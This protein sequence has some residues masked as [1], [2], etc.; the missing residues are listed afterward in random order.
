MTALTYRYVALTDTGLRRSTNQDSGYASDRLLAIADGMGG[1]AAGDLASS[2]AMHII[3]RLDRDLDVSAID[4]LDQ[5]VKLAND[6]LGEL[7]REDP[8]V[9][10]MGT[11]LEVMVWDGEKLAVAHLGDS[12]AY[13]LRGGTLTQISTD[14]TFVQS[15]VE[16]GKISRAEARVHPH[17]SLLLRALLGR[18]DN[19][20]DLSWIQPMLGDRYLLCSDGLT[21][22]VEDDVIQR[23]LSAE[24]ID[25]A[26]TELVRLALEAGGVDNVTVV[27]AEF[28]EK[29]TEPDPHLSSSDGQPQLV[30]AAANQARPRTGTASSGSDSAVELDPEEL[31]YAPQPPARRRW[32]R[33]TAAIVVVAAI[34]AAGGAYAYNWS[35]DQFYVAAS[36]GRVAIYRGVQVDIPGI[37]LSHVDELTDIEL[38]SLSDFQRR[39][40]EDGVEA[41]S[42]A[43]ARR[44]VAELDVIAPTPTPTPTPT[45]KSTPAPSRTTKTPTSANVVWMP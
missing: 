14:H 33:W 2:E 11:T 19:A 35:Q 15:L 17:R 31:R 21:D 10:G 34:L 1:A 16:E 42:K 8:A 4:A 43:D 12:R 29:G 7:I 37:T 40:I 5:S 24:T 45:R 36:E 25:M 22:M 26:A 38:S 41:S 18:D 44:T 6:R 23:A 13:R 39:E 3:R 32:F 27:I 9:E 28:V 30:G 20:A